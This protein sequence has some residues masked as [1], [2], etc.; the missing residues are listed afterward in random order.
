MQPLTCEAAGVGGSAGAG[1]RGAESVEAADELDT[2]AAGMF[3]AG[4]PAGI[5]VT[6]KVTYGFSSPPLLPL[7]GL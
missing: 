2:E 3:H 4:R 6:R 5:V 1:R 7:C